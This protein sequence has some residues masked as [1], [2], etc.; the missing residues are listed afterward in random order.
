MGRAREILADDTHDVTIKAALRDACRNGRCDVVTLL[1]ADAR[2]DP[3][4]DDK[5]ALECACANG[6]VEVVSMLLTNFHLPFGDYEYA[7]RHALT[8][9]VV[10]GHCD[11]VALMVQDPR[12]NPWLDKSFALEQYCSVGDVER[13]K[14]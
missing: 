9:A 12:V 7:I 6:Q 2:F 4:V 13:A 14:E 5:V 8:V 11:V 1:T 10:A 3:S